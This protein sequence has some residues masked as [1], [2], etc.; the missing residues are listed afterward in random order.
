M[1]D[2]LPAPPPRLRNFAPRAS[3]VFIL[4]AGAPVWRL[5]CHRPHSTTWSTFRHA[6]PSVNARFDHHL[7]DRTSGRS[8]LYAADQ[9]V[10]CLAEVF[11]ET[12][13]IDPYA[14]NMPRL[15]EF[16]FDADL[17][18][19]DV[20]GPWITRAGGS[21][22]INAGLRDAARRWSRAIYDA[23]ADIHGLRYASSMHANQPCYAFYDRAAPSIASAPL[24]DEQLSHP[25]LERLL[26]DAAR[27]LGYAL[28]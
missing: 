20:A 1:A 14:A 5:Y 15:A 7:D 16:A 10:T 11:Q 23:F 28:A 27:T 25:E 22:A 6:G 8:I 2:R 17:R 12:R 4:E 18:L 3:E 9:S 13:A 19:L 21:M 26:D 24:F